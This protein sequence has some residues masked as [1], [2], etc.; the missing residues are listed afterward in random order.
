M[1]YNFDIVE[2]HLTAE[3]KAIEE[4]KRRQEEERL[5][6][7]EGDNVGQRG[8]KMMLGGT[9]EMKKNKGIM[10][11]TLEKEEWMDKPIEDMTEEEKLKLKE[12]QQKEKELQ[13]EKE[14]KRKAWDQE[15]RKLKQEIDE[16]CAKFEQRLKELQKKRLFYDMRIY[17]QELYIIRLTLMLH[18]NKEIK[19]EEKSIA[20]K[21]GKVEVELEEA[22]DAVNKFGEMYADFDAKYK[23]NTA[24]IDQEKSLKQKYPA[25]RA[26]LNFVKNGGKSANRAQGFGAT[27]EKSAR[28]KELMSQLNELDPYI[29][30]DKN[31]I[32]KI[33]TE[34]NAKEHYS[35]EKDSFQNLSPEEFDNVVEERM[36]R[37][38]MNKQR[39]KMEEEINHIKEHQ[40]F[41]NFNANELEEAF[42]EIKDS[43]SEIVNRMVRL[44]YNF[45][46]VVYLLQGQVEVP[47][48]PVAT[49]YKDAILIKTN[50]I[51]KE[52]SEVIKRGD[53][54]VQKLEDIT[55]FKKDLYHATWRNDQLLLE[56]KDYTERAIDVQLYKVKKE[57]QEIIKGNHRTKDEDEKKR[58]ESQIK[59]FEDNANTRIST[60]NQKKKK[61]KKEIK[62]KQQE[63]GQ[64]EMRARQLQQNVDQRKQI[65][66]LRSKGTDD[67]V[68][69]PRKRFKEISSVRKFKEIVEQ[70]KEE[71]EFLEDELERHRSR[72]FPS[73]ANMHSR[74][75]YAD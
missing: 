33:I 57:T 51:E 50:V 14:K 26:I 38:E 40:S 1:K 24:I 9:L 12:F 11:E 73:F 56:I 28:E 65:M 52:N 58:I 54:N 21:K 49:D 18:E 70:Q 63:N 47:Q 2:K 48:A 34:E 55:N 31:A 35:Y 19:E 17:E 69:D 29:I 66:E 3:E 53:L 10:Q 36:N 16:I 15:Y 62:D 23:E 74:Q 64:L 60:I 41:C 30:V 4:E 61:L 67:N 44:K 22:K 42:E 59:Q 72:T 8:I 45:E 68:Q 32:K 39:E 75:D 6:A 43:H 25:S 46:V 37:I 5:K 13:E 20:E 27:Q 71:I 7:L